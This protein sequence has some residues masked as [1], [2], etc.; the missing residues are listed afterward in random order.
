MGPMCRIVELG[1]QALR[2][3][4]HRLGGDL[5]PIFFAVAAQRFW[6]GLRRSLLGKAPDGVADSE[7][8][9]EHGTFPERE[10]DLVA[11]W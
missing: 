6:F 10:A 2:A 5:A 9:A 1:T 8:D 11:D 3:G 7:I 4:W